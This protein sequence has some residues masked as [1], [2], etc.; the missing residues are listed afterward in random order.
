MTRWTYDPLVKVWPR[1]YWASSTDLKDW[2]VPTWADP[3]GIDPEL[4][5]D[6][7]SDKVY[8]NVMAPSSNEESLWGIYQCEVSLESGKCIGRY[9]SLWNGTLPLNS[10]ARPEGP[11]MFRKDDW[12]YLLIA[13]GSSWL[14]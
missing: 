5:H 6:P 11:K 9:H 12:Y 1:I 7:I 14:S 3:Y 4:F 8:L 2:S 13:E 10:D